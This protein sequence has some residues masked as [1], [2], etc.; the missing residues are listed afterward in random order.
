MIGPGH[1]AKASRPPSPYPL[2]LTE[3]PRGLVFSEICSQRYSA[4]DREFSSC[5]GPLKVVGSLADAQRHEG[6]K[7]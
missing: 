5:V 2:L 3:L 6:D 1:W 4:K 7:A